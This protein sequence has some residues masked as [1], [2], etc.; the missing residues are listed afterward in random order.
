MKIPHPLEV[1]IKKGG[2]LSYP[3]GVGINTE[4]PH[5]I[6]FLKKKKFIK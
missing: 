4:Y 1:L 2:I 6:E 5:S 3:I